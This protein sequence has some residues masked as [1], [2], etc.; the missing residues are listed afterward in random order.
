MEAKANIKTKV[1]GNPVEKLLLDIR[2]RNYWMDDE[3]FVY[4]E[5]EN[6]K[7]LYSYHEKLQELVIYLY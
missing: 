3:G 2:V 6:N 4:L 5:G 7:L 1:D